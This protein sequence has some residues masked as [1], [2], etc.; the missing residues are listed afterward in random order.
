VTIELEDLGRRFGTFALDQISLRLERGEYRVLLGPSGCGKSMLLQTL[1]G[2]F[3][4]DAGRIRVDGKD[5]TAL[6]PERRDIGL[7]FQQAALF[8]HYSVLGNVEYGLRARKVPAD[9]RRRRVDEVVQGLGLEGILQ[10]P[11]PTLSGG[12]AQR[13]AIAR[14]LALRPR[15][16]LLDEPLSLLDHNTRLALQSELKRVH[17]AFGLTTL[18]VT[19]S[20]EEA[21]ALGDRCAVMCAGRLVQEGTLEEMRAR[22][23]SPFVAEFLGTA[24]TARTA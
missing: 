24:A 8:P 5:V 4:P 18:H 13:V 1:T 16:L 10:R 23:A 14:A 12:E 2:L 22:P 21:A 7:V 15:L 9:E 11:V 20:R 3:L 19:H 6:P 17:T